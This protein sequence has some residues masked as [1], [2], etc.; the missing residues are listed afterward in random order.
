MRLKSAVSD[1]KVDWIIVLDTSEGPLGELAAFAQEPT[2]VI[3]T[4]VL[5]PKDY[6]TPQESFP[7]DILEH[8]INRWRFNKEELERC[9]LVRE[10]MTRAQRGRVQAWPELK[11]MS[12]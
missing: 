11:S 8:Y 12:F 2:I 4:F 10:C 5:F 7:S 9:D 3:K 6:Y 1:S